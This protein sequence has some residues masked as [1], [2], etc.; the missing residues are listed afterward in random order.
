MTNSNYIEL[1]VLVGYMEFENEPVYIDPDTYQ[2]IYHSELNDFE[3]DYKI[4]DLIKIPTY[5]ELPVCKQF[6]MQYTDIRN[7]YNHYSRMLNLLN[8]IEERDFFGKFYNMLIDFGL[9]EEWN[10][11]YYEKC[12][13]FAERWCW[14]NN[15]K[16]TKKKKI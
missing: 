7:K 5:D 2:F 1:D 13:E 15:L 8:N 3:R 4:A 16:Y 12:C 14:E 10:I 9:R 11:Y 6:L